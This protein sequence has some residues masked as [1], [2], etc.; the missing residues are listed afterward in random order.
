[1]DLEPSGYKL[2]V[3]VYCKGKILHLSD[4]SLPYTNLPN[5]YDLT[6]ETLA[7]LKYLFGLRFKEEQVYELGME[8]IDTDHVNFYTGLVLDYYPESYTDEEPIF[9]DLNKESPEVKKF[10]SI[11]PQLKF[12]PQLKFEYV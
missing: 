12:D 11:F 6:K 2:F 4:T 7:L 8:V 5:V 3:L 9:I 10:V 1:M